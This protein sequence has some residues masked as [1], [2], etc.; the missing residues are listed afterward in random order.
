MSMAS[1]QDIAQLAQV[2]TATAARG[3]TTLAASRTLGVVQAQ[4][5]ARPIIG[6]ITKTETNPFFVKMTEGAQKDATRLGA[7]RLTADRRADA[8]T[9]RRSPPSRTWSPA[10]TGPS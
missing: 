4:S 8:T 1:I 5:T 2:S 7:T 6:L 3:L 9:P 10:A